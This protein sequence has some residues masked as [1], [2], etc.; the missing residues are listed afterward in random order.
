MALV[1][2]H[3][4]FRRSH[5]RAGTHAPSKENISSFATLRGLTFDSRPF[6]GW[7][8]Y[9]DHQQITNTKAQHRPGEK[10]ENGSDSL[11]WIFSEW[12]EGKHRRL[13]LRAEFVFESELRKF[14]PG[15]VEGR[16]D[17][18]RFE[19][20]TVSLGKFRSEVRSWRTWSLIVDSVN[21]FPGKDCEDNCLRSK[22]RAMGPKSAGKFDN[23]VCCTATT[24]RCWRWV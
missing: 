10:T 22:V 16:F 6:A 2:W 9:P 7:K 19:F 17:A 21:E 18:V 13:Q 24:R 23:S 3:F 4:P 12:R 15:T 5:V 14:Y 20:V 8:T 11:V 1:D